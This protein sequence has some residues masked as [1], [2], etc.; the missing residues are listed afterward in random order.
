MSKE[1]AEE[2]FSLFHQVYQTRMPIKNY[3][4]KFIWPDGEIAYTEI[5]IFPMLDRNN[6]I[7]GFRAIGREITERKNAEDKLNYMATHD[8]LTG[9][10]NRMLLMDRLKMATAQAKR[11]DHKLAL[12]MLDLDNFKSVNDSLGHMIGDELLKEIATR[13]TGRLR[14]NDTLCRLGGD[15]FILLLP[16]IERNEDAMEVTK[17]VIESFEQPFTCGGHT[18]AS[19]VSI[20]IA[21]Y[22]D[23]AQDVDILMRNAD[24]AMYYVKAHGRNGYHFFTAEINGNFA[25]QSVQ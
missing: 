18:I 10:P 5:S 21:I 16:A 15:E 13:L 8:L 2:I 7:F 4:Y 23:D 24:V 12:M 6:K 17:I 11:N 14:Q 22:P 19:T 3:P 25:G 1:Q 9:L 20:G